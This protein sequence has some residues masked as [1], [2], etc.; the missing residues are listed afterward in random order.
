RIS[1]TGNNVTPHIWE[2]P[3]N[4]LDLTV[5]QKVFKRF[6]LKAG[7]KDILNETRRFVQYSGKRDEGQE[8]DVVR[9]KASRIFNIGFTYN[10]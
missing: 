3:Y 1:F 2:L 8:I 5:S 7:I 4:S 10:F 9:Y 6:E